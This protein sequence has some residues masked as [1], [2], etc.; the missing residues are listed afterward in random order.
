MSNQ[1]RAAEVIWDEQWS[2]IVKP[3]DLVEALAD[4]GLLMP[5]L[6][7]DDTVG[8]SSG[9]WSAGFDYENEEGNTYQAHA[10]AWNPGKVGISAPPIMD[11]DDAEAV[12]LAILAA[13]RSDRTHH[14]EQEQA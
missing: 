4:A 1:E 7:T 13:V 8:M 2:G 9:E 6:P 10:Y 11:T 14:T 5:D 12:A 3:R